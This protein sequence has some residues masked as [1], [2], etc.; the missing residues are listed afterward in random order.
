MAETILRTLWPLL[1]AMTVLVPL[2]CTNAKGDAHVKAPVNLKAVAGVQRVT[3]SWDPAPGA[4]IY[5]LYWTTSSDEYTG[6][7]V[8]ALDRIS[9][10]HS[11]YDHQGLTPG[12]TYYY[13]VTSVS[14]DWRSDVSN[15]AQAIPLPP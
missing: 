6:V 1:T 3:L 9:I 12:A 11:P 2:G 13:Y 15:R 8:N 7:T 14:G 5:W 4:E 10:S